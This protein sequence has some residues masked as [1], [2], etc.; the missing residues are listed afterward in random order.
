MHRGRLIECYREPLLASSDSSIPIPSYSTGSDRSV[1][2]F[3]CWV[4]AS[5]AVALISGGGAGGG[6]GCKLDA[7]CAARAATHQDHLLMHAGRQCMGPRQTGG[8]DT[9]AYRVLAWSC[10]H[11]QG[12]AARC[13]GFRVRALASHAHYVLVCFSRLL[14]LVYDCMRLTTTRHEAQL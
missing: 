11:R 3:Q 13:S 12:A 7:C 9:P 1:C 5:S 6:S 8:P 14:L 10:R 2:G 4:I